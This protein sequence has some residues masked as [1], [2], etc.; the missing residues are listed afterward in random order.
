MRYAICNEIFGA[1]SFERS[2]GEAADAGYEGV[3]VAP[4][5][6]DDDPTTITDERAEAAGRAAREAGVA[7][8]GLHWLLVRPDGLHLTTT[9]DR[10]RERTIQFL[11]HLARVCAAMEGKV[12]V[13]GSP[14]Q[15]DVPDGESYEDTF[16]R[17]RD[18]CRTVAETA[19]PLGVTLALEPLTPQDTNF[20]TSAAETAKLVRAV[21]HEGCRLHLDVRAMCSEPRPVPE[22]IAAHAGEFVHFHAN[23]PN[24]G[25]PGSGA[26]DYAPI[27]RSLQ[28]AGYDGWV[29]VEVFDTTL[30]GRAVARQSL[31]YLRQACG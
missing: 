15:R 25:G 18:A 27:F 23:D 21:D 13:L 30:D 11:Q 22:I 5:T 8:C 6:I 10:I 9:D 2:C 14:K 20:L 28:A 3:E 1:I 16:R 7:V 12:L 4:F 19:A 26:V 17:T 31:E 29:S 24:L